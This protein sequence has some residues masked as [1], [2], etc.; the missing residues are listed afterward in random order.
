MPGMVAVVFSL[1][2]IEDV[3]TLSVPDV[4][5]VTF[6]NGV[7]I[8]EKGE[9]NENGEEKGAENGKEGES[10]ENVVTE[11]I[12]KSS[13]DDMEAGLNKLQLQN[14]HENNENQDSSEESKEHSLDKLNIPKNNNEES[15][16]EAEEESDVVEYKMRF[17][18]PN[19]INFLANISTNNTNN[20]NNSNI[21][22]NNA[23]NEKNV[24]NS[25]NESTTEIKELTADNVMISLILDTNSKAPSSFAFDMLLFDGIKVGTIVNPKGGFPF[26]G[27]I[28]VATIGLPENVNTCTVRIRG[29]EKEKP[30]PGA[31]LLLLFI[32]IPGIRSTVSP[33]SPEII[34]TIPEAEMMSKV[35]PVIIK[36]AKMYFIDISID[37]GCS[38]DSSPTAI[39]QIM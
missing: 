22:N 30:V 24:N 15:N 29:E 11:A 27:Q 16:N 37:G 4:T 19:I 35:N 3:I 8:E 20:V 6:I 36:K 26:G 14:K 32:E 12:I 34:F 9:N 38:F 23:N 33:G 18:M 21:A 25:N 13:K 7:E 1:P 10:K 17:V 2:G 31:P 39:L 5:V 28:N